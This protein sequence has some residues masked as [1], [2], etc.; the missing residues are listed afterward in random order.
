MNLALPSRMQS[1]VAL[2]SFSLDKRK[3]VIFPILLTCF[4]LCREPKSYAG[5]SR[6]ML[7]DT[8]NRSSVSKLFRR[9]RLRSRNIYEDAAACIAEQYWE[10]EKNIGKKVW[11]LA[12]D[13]VCNKRGGF[14]KIEN[15]TKYRKKRKDKGP[16]TKAHTFVMGLLIT[17]TG[18]R[19]PLPRRTYNTRA[20]CRKHKKKYI[21]ITELAALIIES[22]I[23]P[24]DVKVIVVAD[25]Y[26][27]G[28]LLDTTCNKRGYTYIVP[29]DSRR[30]FEDKNGKRRKQ[31]LY[32]YGKSL[33]RETLTKIVFRPHQERT[34][35]LR[36]RTGE[37]KKRRTYFAT[38]KVQR[39]SGLGERTIVYSWKPRTKSR[40]WK[41]SWF[42]VL[43]S[44]AKDLDVR[45]LIEYYELRWQIEIFFRELKS[46]MGLTDYTGQ[47]FAAYERF[48]DM[49]L[50]AYLFLEWYRMQLLGECCRQKNR[51]VITSARIETLLRLFQR[52]ADRASIEYIIMCGKKP[53]L[54]SKLLKSI[55]KTVV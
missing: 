9:S 39:I 38:S 35:L 20:Y 50:L 51:A 47:D 25:E 14:A 11:L 24:P 36:R 1:F 46:F 29:V 17:H 26:F 2:F 10:Q 52:E 12:I 31:T 19:I 15:T 37:G 30:C 23:V 21:K 48:I 55:N 40:R 4:L 7:L 16:T 43:I 22:A 34:A 41:K 45:A 42:K 8:R 53:A 5:L 33:I 13:G 49:I 3:S 27:E 6:T 18:V 44:N 28:K 32:E 54:M